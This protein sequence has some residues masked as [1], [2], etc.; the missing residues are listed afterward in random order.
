MNGEFLGKI[1]LVAVLSIAF[2][3]GFYNEQK[4][5]EEGG[6]ESGEQQS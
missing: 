6:V 5:E 2:V 4:D 1:I 3:H